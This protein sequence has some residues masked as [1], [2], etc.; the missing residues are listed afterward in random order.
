MTFD[1]FRNIYPADKTIVG[2]YTADGS[3]TLDSV[4]DIKDLPGS[5]YEPLYTEE[6]FVPFLLYD[7]NDDQFE[8]WNF[9]YWHIVG[10]YV[11]VSDDDNY[12]LV[13]YSDD[14]GYEIL[15]PD[16]PTDSM[17]VFVTKQDA[18][19][20]EIARQTAYE[21][22]ENHKNLLFTYTELEDFM[23]KKENN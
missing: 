20:E 4:E 15:F 16:N 19:L 22:T 13:T 11:D 3:L 17:S 6:G 7:A 21:F 9:A 10:Y 5:K 18:T 8:C 1:E 14:F 2:F 12:G 23:K